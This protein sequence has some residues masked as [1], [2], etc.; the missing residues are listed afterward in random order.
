VGSLELKFSLDSCTFAI[1]AKKPLLESERIC[2][3]DDEDLWVRLWV[4]L[5]RTDGL[6]GIKRRRG[7]V[8]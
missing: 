6:L 8:V 1:C 2:G 4:A 7:R 5:G 3:R